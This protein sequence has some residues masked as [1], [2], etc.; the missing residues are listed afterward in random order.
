EA[1]T[2]R[3]ACVY[4]PSMSRQPYPTLSSRFG[5]HRPGTPGWMRPTERVDWLL[6]SGATMTRFET[7]CCP[8]VPA[9]PLPPPEAAAPD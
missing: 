3:I 7:T 1:D 6:C 2:G 9:G 8:F 4:A 5:A